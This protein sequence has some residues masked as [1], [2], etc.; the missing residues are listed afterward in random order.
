M[1]NQRKAILDNHLTYAGGIKLLL[2]FKIPPVN[3]NIKT[4]SFF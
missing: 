3:C 2:L 4:N 1:L